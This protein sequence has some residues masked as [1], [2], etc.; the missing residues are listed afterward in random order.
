M[1]LP[2]FTEDLNIISSLDDAP[3]MD[4]AELKAKFDE[5]ANLLKDYINEDLIPA[6]ENELVY[7]YEELTGGM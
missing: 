3:Q 5:A 4:A 1:S 6:I 7:L 2:L